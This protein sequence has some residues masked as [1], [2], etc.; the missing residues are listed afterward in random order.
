MGEPAP[1]GV[2]RGRQILAEL[3]TKG[4][5]PA[6]AGVIERLRDV[7]RKEDCTALDV[8]RIILQD[9]GLASK[10]LRLVNSA[11]YRKGGNP[12][13]T[14][15]RAIIVLG[16]ETIRDITV[17]V[18]LIEE[19]VRK[20]G[21]SKPIREGLRRSLFCGLVSQRLSVQVGYPIPEEAYL[22]G[23]FANWGVLWLAAFY[24]SEFERALA[25]A[26]E[27][28]VEIEE[29]AREV[30]GVHPSELSAAILEHWNFP[31]RYAD[32]FR[33]PVPDDRS[34]IAGTAGKLSAI[35]HMAAD[36]A[37]AVDGHPEQA[38]LVMRKFERLFALEQRHFLHAAETANAVLREQAAILGVGPMPAAVPGAPA[39]AATPEGERPG[40]A[41]TPKPAPKAAAAPRA[42][43]RATARPDATAAL[44]IVA[45]ITT[46]I[47]ER[48]DI[49][50]VLFMVLEGVTRA[51]GFDAAFLA[52]LNVQRDRIVGRL[53]HGEGVE[54][55]L[56]TL[57]VPLRADAGVLA[58]TILSRTPKVVGDGDASMLVAPGMAPPAIPARAFVTHPITVRDRTVGVL[59]ALRG[60]GRATAADLTVV[61]LF[62]NQASL[63][64]AQCAG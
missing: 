37:Q 25:L 47:V 15:T 34:A 7:V 50:Q 22:L 53:G 5:F 52:L 39:G 29:A 55:Y 3:G 48:A 43:R 60:E 20:K 8:A 35:V 24:P 41:A 28:R 54:E 2:D 13:S 26:A 10:V 23:L 62:C 51:G 11:F 21:A 61:Q 4:D 64:L 58:E 6:A 33:K 44:A 49:N 40:A 32:Y 38:L 9:A 31:A 45:E 27:R 56:G 46:A 1:T 19:F 30:F 12:V 36:Y 57:A 14:I 18:L 42:P 59:V 63:A 16:F 17:G